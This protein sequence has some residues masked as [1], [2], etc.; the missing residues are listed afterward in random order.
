MSRTI[1]IDSPETRTPIQARARP[2]IL[3]TAAI[4]TLFEF[5]D[6][7]PSVRLLFE[8]VWRVSPKHTRIRLLREEET[9]NAIE[10]DEVS[11]VRVPPAIQ[12]R[13]RSDSSSALPAINDGRGRFA[14]ATPFFFHV[15]PIHGVLI[16][17]YNTSDS[18]SMGW[19]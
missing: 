5:H 15:I 8:G 14:S 16:D 13:I 1:S 6:K 2:P 19:R 18:L 11:G 4:T 9:G 3:S 17:A 10:W 12:V 7:L